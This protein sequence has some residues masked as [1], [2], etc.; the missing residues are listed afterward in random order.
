MDRDRD[1]PYF[2]VLT[3]ERSVEWM[4]ERKRWLKNDEMKEMIPR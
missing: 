2:R 3:G 4:K 1:M